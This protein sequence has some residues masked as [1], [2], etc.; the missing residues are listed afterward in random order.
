MAEY[1]ATYAFNIRRFITH[2]I[3]AESGEEAVCLAKEQAGDKIAAD[4]QVY[5]HASGFGDARD[6]EPYIFLDTA[7]GEQELL[8]EE[9]PENICG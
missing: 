3:V 7:D 4:L 2:R 9:L 8:N 5:M 1:E 6:L